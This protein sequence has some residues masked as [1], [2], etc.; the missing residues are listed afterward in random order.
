VDAN[1]SAALDT[2]LALYTEVAQRSAAEVIRG[3]STSF[4]WAS[5][6]LSPE[7]RIHVSNI[8]ALVRV[9]DEIV[10]GAAEQA[11]GADHLDDAGVLLDELEADCYRAIDTG[12]STN[13]VVHAFAHTARFAGFGR[14]LVEPFFASMRMDLHPQTYDQANFETYIYGSAEVVGLMCLQVYLLGH[15]F[16]AKQ[17]ADFVV[18]AKALGAAFQ[19]VNFLRD[20]AAD[21]RALGR[22]Y[23]PNIDLNNF[24][25]ADKQRLVA[26]ITADLR[27]SASGLISLPKSSRR[28][29]AAAQFLY[30][31]LNRELANTPATKLV[32]TRVRVSN[33]KKLL[34]LLKATIGAIPK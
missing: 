23:F 1:N 24:T 18:S 13:L 32:T 31:A 8:Y 25:E 17:Q 19:K 15:S 28:A 14:E 34:I 7:V 33:A 26:D 12:F 29:V 4:G 27:L 6:L 21:S 20:L 30:E 9:A 2:N 5:K 10:D 16:S 11:L 3:Y 22:S